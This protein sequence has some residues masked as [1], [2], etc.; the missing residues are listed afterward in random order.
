MGKRLGWQGWLT[1]IV[2]ILMPILLTFYLGTQ[3]GYRQVADSIEAYRQIPEI[4]KLVDLTTL[5]AGEIVMLHGQIS[6]AALSPNM[7]E[8]DLIIYQERPAEGRE[9]RFQEE[10]SLIF[11]DFNLVLSDGSLAAIPSQTRELTIQHELHQQPIGD[12]VR[13]GFQAGD[14]VTVQ[15]Q[16]QPDPVPALVDVTGVT[17]GDRA[18]LLTEWETAMRQTRLMRDT[19]GSLSVLA[20][21]IFIGQMRRLRQTANKEEETELCPPQIPE[22][23]ATTSAG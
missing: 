18:T 12:R 22:T 7:P 21:V 3:M 9:V 6:T 5:P 15:G 11:S 23:T 10:F 20:I 13:T 1:M 16:W 14:M 17:G 19:L 2:I 4:T 8:S